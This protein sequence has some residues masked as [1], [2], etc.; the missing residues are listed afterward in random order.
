[1]FCPQCRAEY[2]SGVTSCSDCH[3]EL[4]HSCDGGQPSSAKTDGNRPYIFGTRDWISLCAAILFGPVLLGI[5]SAV[6]GLIYGAA[7]MYYFL[8][9]AIILPLL[10]LI[11][12]RLKACAWQIAIGSL[13]LTVISDPRRAIP[14]SQI[15]PVTF[16]FWA[17]STLLSSP[18]PIYF[19]LRRSA[20]RQRYVYGIAI[21]TTAIALWFGLKAITG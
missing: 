6:P 10:V 20:P 21:A 15:A 12:D 1:M 5:G 17:I 18:V 14:R 11:A 2:L 16:V 4:V 13:T 9:C 19:F 3:I 8:C 7:A